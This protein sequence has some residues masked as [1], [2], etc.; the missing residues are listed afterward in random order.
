MLAERGL[1]HEGARAVQHVA[2]APGRDLGL[3]AELL[4]L[5]RS[6]PSRAA[7]TRPG[8]QFSTSASAWPR[9]SSS[10]SPA[11]K[12]GTVGV[13]LGEQVTGAHH[14]PLEP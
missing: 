11:T 4:G 10:A 8:A 6:P 3:E 1:G 5:G 2:G 12:R 14:Q 7:S 9:H 13:P